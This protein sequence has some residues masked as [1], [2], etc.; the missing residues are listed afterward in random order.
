MDVKDK[1]IEDLILVRK[2][3]D[4]AYKQL[5]TKSVLSKVDLEK[6]KGVYDKYITQ[7]NALLPYLNNNETEYYIELDNASIKDSAQTIYISVSAYQSPNT[8]NKEF[9]YKFPPR[10]FFLSPGKYLIQIRLGDM[11]IHEEI[12][13]ILYTRSPQYT[14]IRILPI[15]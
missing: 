8:Y 14:K 13:E 15:H 4:S 9:E 6:V 3:L 12:R 1:M 7:K 2:K 5:L 11:K 10:P